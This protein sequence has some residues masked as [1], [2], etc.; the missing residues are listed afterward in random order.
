MRRS[1]IIFL[2][3]LA[4][5]AGAYYYL[6]NRAKTADSSATAEP[7]TEVSYLFTS[8]DG[9]PTNIHIESKTGDA[10]EV[11]RGAD[12]AWAL[13][14]PAKAAADQGSVEAAASQV[15]TLRVLARLPDVAPKDVGLDVPHQK[16]TPNCDRASSNS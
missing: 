13:I 10:V 5:M 2:I 8:T 6:N 7:T 16:I 9:V 4:L 15:T 12:N 14:L 1:T 11:A 3:L